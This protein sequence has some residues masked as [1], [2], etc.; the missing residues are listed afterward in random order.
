[1]IRHDP[2]KEQIIIVIAIALVATMIIQGLVLNSSYTRV[3]VQ[4]LANPSSEIK[5]EKQGQ[6]IITTTRQ[7]LHELPIALQQSP[8][9]IHSSIIS[10]PRSIDFI[11][12][13]S[14]NTTKSKFFF[15]YQ[16]NSTLGIKIQYP[17]KWKEVQ[18][19]GIGVIFI[20]PPESNSDR[21]LEKLTIAV[22]PSNNNTSVNKLVNEAINN[23]RD[24]YPDFQLIESKAITFKT[25]PAYTIVYSYTDQE[26]REVM[27]MDVGTSKDNRVYVFSYSA[28]PSEYSSNMPTI[29]KMINSFETFP[30]NLPY[31][32]KV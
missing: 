17:P 30:V 25:N 15:T 1:M 32:N 2:T 27:A 7:N 31:S 9:P 3:L 23:Y 21:F 11:N 14:T 5:S 22:F 16:N 4:S 28:D 10:T 13:T 26:L 20:S 18:V 6:I 24:R 19:D 8:D 29:L 12:A